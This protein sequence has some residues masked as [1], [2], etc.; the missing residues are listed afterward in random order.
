MK[1]V[2][3]EYPVENQVCSLEQ[4]KKLSELLGDDTPES[5]WVYCWRVDVGGGK[6]KLSLILRIDYDDDSFYRPPIY[7]AY[8][9]DELGALLPGNIYDL[10]GF[11]SITKSDHNPGFPI[12][13]HAA[14]TRDDDCYMAFYQKSAETE[15]QAKADLAIHLLKRKIIQPEEFKY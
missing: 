14:Y 4:A 12:K 5:L 8:T 15:A 7:P 11:L 2:M 6:D 9:G 10:A 3:K 13:H 1:T